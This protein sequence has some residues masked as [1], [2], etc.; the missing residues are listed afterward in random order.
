MPRFD[1]IMGIYYY[2][3]IF[4]AQVG[5]TSISVHVN[6]GPHSATAVCGSYATK[7][8]GASAVTQLFCGPTFG[9]KSIIF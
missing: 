2:M 1:W 5:S 4:G 3:W 6:F 7:M 8:D 9:V